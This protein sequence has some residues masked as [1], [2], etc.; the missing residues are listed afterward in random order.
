MKTD[1]TLRQ[2]PSGEWAIQVSGREPV[3]I[4]AGEVFMVKV[5]G[6]MKRTRLAQRA[7]GK[8]HSTTGLEL[9]DGMQAR[10]FDQREWHAK[11]AMRA[12]IGSER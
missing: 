6:K 1:G 5:A 3:R 10:F 4:L 7:D 9:R 2:F 12:A 11:I 8:Y